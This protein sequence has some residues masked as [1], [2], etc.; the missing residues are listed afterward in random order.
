MIVQMQQENQ[1]IYYHTMY[2]RTV[3]SINMSDIDFATVAFQSH[4]LDVT[5]QQTIIPVSI[6]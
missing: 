3:R 6:D 2:N 5:K 1:K 4:P